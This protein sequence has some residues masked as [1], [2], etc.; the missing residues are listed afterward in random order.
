MFTMQQ[1]L[2]VKKIWR[3]LRR[4]DPS[5]VTGA[6]SAKLFSDHPGL[7]K[8]FQ[9]DMEPQYVKLMDMLNAEVARLYKL[10]ELT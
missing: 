7:R 6:F 2:L 3:M 5:I 1:I 10:D 8:M 4:I 9:K